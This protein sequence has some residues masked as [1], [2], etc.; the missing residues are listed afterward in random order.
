MSLKVCMMV[1]IKHFMN[2]NYI[3]Y[4]ELQKNVN[5]IPILKNLIPKRP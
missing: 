4:N 5:I 3:S 1:E 2:L